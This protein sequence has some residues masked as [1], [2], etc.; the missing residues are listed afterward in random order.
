MV[1]KSKRFKDLFDLTDIEYE[2]LD[3]RSWFPFSTENLVL[4]KKRR[5]EERNVIDGES[6]IP[7]KIWLS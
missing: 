4:K 1:R 6:G 3:N 5:K 2:Y 7:N